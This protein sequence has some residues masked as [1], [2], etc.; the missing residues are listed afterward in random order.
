VLPPE[1]L[2]RR[3]PDYTL[4]LVWNIANEIVAQQDAYLR[5]GGH[6]IVPIPAVRVI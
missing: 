3:R 4:L 1:E 6:F 2:M 5:A